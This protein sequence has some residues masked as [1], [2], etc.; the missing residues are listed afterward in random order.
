MTTLSTHDTKRGED[1][2]ARLAVL[3]ELPETWAESVEGWRRAAAG[4]HGAA[5]PDPA[6]EYLIWQTLVGAWPLDADRLV[7]YLHKATREAKLHT[8]W[9]TPNAE[10]DQAVE[11]FARALLDDARLVSGISAFVDELAPAARAVTLGQ[12]LVQLTMPGVPDVYQGTEFATFTLVDPDNRRPVDFAARRARLAVLR[13]GESP[14]DL[15]DEKLLVTAWALAV[16]RDH[17]DAFA[18]DYRE[19]PATS[20][21]AF[22]FV[23]GDRVICAVTRL[24]RRLAESG[25]WGEHSVDLP[26]GAWQDVL[27]DREYT[28]GP[29]GAA[30]LFDRFPVALLVRA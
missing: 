28:G 5:G 6:T 17:P 13:A 29:H 11:Q 16:R 25:G 9:T 8:S 30:K 20:P 2:R 27:T 26:A 21:H 23:R 1:V 4:Y 12:K 14:R 15:N 3:A 22:G 18:G 7:E 24:P 19:L 10:Y